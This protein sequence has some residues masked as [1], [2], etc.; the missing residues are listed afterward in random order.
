M[1]KSRHLLFA[2]I[3]SNY[4]ILD[5]MFSVLYIYVDKYGY[6]VKHCKVMC[7]NDILHRHGTDTHFVLLSLIIHFVLV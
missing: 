2:H 5:I 1:P 6:K 4:S 3:T 7:D